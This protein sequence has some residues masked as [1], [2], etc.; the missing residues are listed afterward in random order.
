MRM[1]CFRGEGSTK[2][3]L[4]PGKPLPPTRI[5]TAEI[6]VKCTNILHFCVCAF[7]IHPALDPSSD[8]A[9]AMIDYLGH[10]PS[11]LPTD[12]Q[13][14]FTRLGRGED[15]EERRG[16]DRASKREQERKHIIR[17]IYSSS[18]PTAVSLY[19]TNGASSTW[20]GWPSRRGAL[21]YIQ[22]AWGH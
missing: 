19:F 13:S 8:F 1:L 22:T 15:S 16:A 5:S 7:S 18:F 4:Q 3:D 21:Y 6:E 12:S 2:L 14:S 11:R 10:P 20:P 9:T 17:S